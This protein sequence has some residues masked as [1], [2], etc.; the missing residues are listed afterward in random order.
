MQ[1]PPC[2]RQGNRKAAENARKIAK[3]LSDF[4]NNVARAKAYIHQNLEKAEG[5]AYLASLYQQ[6]SKIE[7]AIRQY[8]V[9]L[10][11]DPRFTPAYHHLAELYIQRRDLKQATDV[12][13]GALRQMPEDAQTRVM[14]AQLYKERNQMKEAI[15]QLDIA[16]KLLEASV[17]QGATIKHLEILSLVYAAKGLYGK[18]EA[19]VKEM[20]KSAPNNPQY[21]N[22]LNAIRAARRRERKR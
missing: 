15:E 8:R 12:Y 17:K 20:I 3:Q 18:A 22:Q 14:L 1:G 4:E 21:Q 2:I 7:Q 6:H 5:Y 9:A 19:V 13:R 11:V 16:Q 10:T